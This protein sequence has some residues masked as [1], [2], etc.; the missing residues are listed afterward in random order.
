MKLNVLC[1]GDIVGRPGKRILADNL[2][3]IIKQHDIDCVVANA[4]NAAGGSGLTRQIYDKLLKYGVNIVTLG[5][6][7][8]KKKDIISVLESNSNITRPM[9]FSKYAAGKDFGLYKTSKGPTIAVVPLIGRVFM[10]PADN[11]FDAV[12]SILPKL[13]SLADIVIV[14]IHAE[15]TSEKIA[16]GYYLDGRVSCV[17]GTHTHVATADEKI[18]SKGTG[19]I[20]DIGMTGAHLSV[21]GRKIESVIK[22]FKTR[23]PCPFEVASEDL[24]ING[25]IVTIDSTSKKAEKISRFEFKDSNSDSIS[26]DADDGKPDYNSDFE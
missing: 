8:Y 12:D 4:E 2:A 15:A 17:F 23:M 25:V 18:M 16:L 1:I 21:L 7:T 22:N 10:K 3:A 5:D 11:P 24:R 20:T 9:N 14:E 13:N 19:Y 26:Y 6:H